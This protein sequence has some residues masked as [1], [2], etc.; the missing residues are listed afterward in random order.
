M[1]H[2]P[3]ITAL[4]ASQRP[5]FMKAE[6]WKLL[7]EDILEH[8]IDVTTPKIELIRDDGE[9]IAVLSKTLPDDSI[10]ITYQ[11]L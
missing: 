9:H 6:D 3:G 8:I 11:K 2:K 10:M 4:I 1:N 5:F 7:K